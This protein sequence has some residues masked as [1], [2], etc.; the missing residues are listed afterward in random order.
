[1]AIFFLASSFSDATAS[2]HR[3]A[4]ASNSHATFSSA[5]A[6]YH[7]HQSM[8]ENCS[9]LGTPSQFLCVEEV[10]LSLLG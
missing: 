2:R 6:F 4:S 1:M 10:E 8:F 3:L 5:W 9:I 7:H